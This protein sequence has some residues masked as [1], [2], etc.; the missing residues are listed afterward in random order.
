MRT[1]RDLQNQDNSSDSE[2]DA[3]QDFFAGGEKSGLAVQNPDRPTDH[4]NNIVNQA[5][6]WVD[7]TLS[8][9]WCSS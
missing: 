1:F 4:F 8:Q 5:R 6:Q 3:P 2:E 9:V 7:S